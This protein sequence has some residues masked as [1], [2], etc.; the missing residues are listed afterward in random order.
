[1]S[2]SL[3]RLDAEA[4]DRHVHRVLVIAARLRLQIV[5]PSMNRKEIQRPID[6]KL[7][8]GQHLDIEALAGQ[9]ENLVG[10]RAESGSATLLLGTAVTRATP[11]PCPQLLQSV[12]RGQLL[13][14][15]CG[16]Q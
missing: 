16:S 13:P 9:R 10:A 7:I 2:G 4:A 11:R 3:R 15:R 12:A 6:A 5:E 8:V 14:L 1:M